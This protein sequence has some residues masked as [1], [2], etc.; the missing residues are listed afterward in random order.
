LPLS[1]AIVAGDRVYLSGTLGNDDTT[2]DNA[3]AQTRVTLEKL[4]KTLSAAGC[5]V[6]DVVDAV[7]Y[8]TDPAN[9]PAIDREYE[10]FFGSHHLSRT[11]IR[12]GLV[13]PDGLVEIMLAAQLNAH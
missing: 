8:V 5:T 9:L 2:R 1:P 4:R 3:G 11:T 12:C 13:A 10:A 7:V 6:E